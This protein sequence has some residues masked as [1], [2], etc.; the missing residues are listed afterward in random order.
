MST[1][2][3][4]PVPAPRFHHV[5]V[6]TN[7]L[8]NAVRWYQDFFG[9]RQSWSLTTFSDLTH[10]RLPGI[11]R[12]TEMVLGDFHVHLFERPGQD[13][14]EPGHSQV[15][16]QHVCLATGSGEEMVF[17]RRRWLELFASGRYKF[18]FDDQ[19]TEI[20]T[21]ADGTQS[22]YALDVNGLEFEFTCLQNAGA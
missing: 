12:L 6:Q 15:Q 5:G 21:D 9:S 13:A 18:A 2:H 19:P 7:D 14:P 10:R 16:F 8:D 20:V 4:H 3:R 1:S 22:F 17:W 11:T